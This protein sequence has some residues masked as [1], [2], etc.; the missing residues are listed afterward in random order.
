MHH[1]DNLFANP[2]AE[3]ARFISQWE[4]ISDYFKNYPDSLLFEI[5]N[6]P[7]D[8]LTPALWN[9]YSKEALSVIRKTNPER[10]VLLGTAVGVV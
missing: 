3:K 10:C 5:L 4:Q 8:K 6:E 9:E 7:H 1:H 2:S